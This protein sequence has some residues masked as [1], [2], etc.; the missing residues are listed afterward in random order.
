MAGQLCG[1]QRSKHGR[2]SGLGRIPLVL[3]PRPRWIPLDGVFR[4]AGP[5]E[6]FEVAE[7]SRS[8]PL[9]LV[10]M[11]R[12]KVA[13]RVTNRALSRSYGNSRRYRK[14]TGNS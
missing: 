4:M 12:H 6:G 14:I 3:S 5:R 2:M 11:W 1:L 9:R 13:R 8:E 10:V 7:R